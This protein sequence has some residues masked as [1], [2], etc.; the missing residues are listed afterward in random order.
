VEGESKGGDAARAAVDE[1][2]VVGEIYVSHETL[3]RDANTKG[4]APECLFLR[5]GVH[6]LLHVLGYEHGS[7]REAR[8]MEAEEKRLLVGHL[9]LA[10]VEELF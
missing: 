1:D 9:N 10:E 3:F 4:V 8:W 6:G 2:D 7:E 5:I